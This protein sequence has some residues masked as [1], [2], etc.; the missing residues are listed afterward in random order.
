MNSRT[1]VLFPRSSWTRNFI[2]LLNRSVCVLLI[3]DSFSSLLSINPLYWVVL[4]IYYIYMVL[5]NV[6]FA[7]C[8]LKE[9]LI[10]E[11]YTLTASSGLE[12]SWLPTT[13]VCSG[14]PFHKLYLEPRVFPTSCLNA[15]TT[16]NS[17]CQ[18]SIQ[19]NRLY[20]GRAERPF[21]ST[22]LSLYARNTDKKV[23]ETLSKL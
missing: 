23:Y 6:I 9:V 13:V 19:P 22:A 2:S 18:E 20:Q 14:W 12:G 1:F 21:S 10:Q 8:K 7:A 5:S 17:P 16:N 3:G 15:A 11:S 4:I